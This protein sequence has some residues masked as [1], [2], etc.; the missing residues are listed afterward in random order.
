MNTKAIIVGINKFKNQID[1]LADKTELIAIDFPKTQTAI[2]S[3]TK[4]LPKNN[5]GARVTQK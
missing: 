2:E 3:L 5:E 1:K 4:N